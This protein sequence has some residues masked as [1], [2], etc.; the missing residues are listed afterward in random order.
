MCG[1]GTQVETKSTAKTVW[2]GQVA[3]LDTLPLPMAVLRSTLLFYLLHTC[4]QALSLG[5]NGRNRSSW[6]KRLF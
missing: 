6:Y 5:I 2:A 1:E 4:Q 3:C